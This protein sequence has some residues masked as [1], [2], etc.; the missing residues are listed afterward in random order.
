MGGRFSATCGDAKHGRRCRLERTCLANKTVPRY[1]AQG[2]P[3]GLLAAWLRHSQ[4]EESQADHMASVALFG[5]DRRAACRAELLLEP[6]AQDLAS[7]ERE[8]RPGEDDEPEG[9]A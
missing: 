2:R 7:E 6:R 9:L 1:A 8:K 5:K 3:L 4:S